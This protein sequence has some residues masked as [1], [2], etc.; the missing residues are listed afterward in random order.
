MKKIFFILV[1]FSQLLHAQHRYKITGK[2]VEESTKQPLEYATISFQ[3]TKNL[4]ELTG[5]ITDVKGHFSVEVPQGNYLLKIQFFSYKTHQIS[6]FSVQE[7]KN[8]GTIFLKD[9][10]SQLSGIE[11]VGKKSTVEMHLDKK[12]YNVGDDMTIKGGSVTDVLDNVPSVS[13][14]NEGNISLRGNENVKVLINGKPSALSGMNAESLKQLPAEMIEKVEI[15]TNPSARYEAEGS[16]GIINIILKKGQNIGLTG[17]VNTN[18]GVADTESYGASVNLNFRKNKFNIFNTTSYRYGSAIS[19]QIFEQEFL[20]AS[21]K[22]NFQN[23]FR[24][25]TRGQK[26]VT[27]NTGFEYFLTPK[28]TITNS[29]V[30]GSNR[31]WVNSQ[32]HITNL[33]ALK[34]LISDRL[35]LGNEKEKEYNLQYTFNIEQKFNDNGH[36]LTADYQYSQRNHDKNN[37][38]TDFQNEQVFDTQSQKDHLIKIDYIFPFS[39]KSQFE[40]GYQG[41]FKNRENQYD[42]FDFLPSPTL[43]TNFS[44]HL[45]YSENINAIYGQFGT[46]IGNFN[47]M[48]G[49]RF[50]DSNIKI[51]EIKSE[52]KHKKYASLFPSLFLGYEFS[53]TNQLSISYTR[54]LQRP[55]GRFINPFT[56]RTGN[57]NLFQGNPDLDPSYTNA[58]D[59]G[60]LTRLGKITLNTSAYYNY[61]TQIFQFVTT[62]SGQ[63]VTIN[64]L[65]V[66][67]MINTPIN[68]ATQN[69]YGVELTANFSPKTNWNFSWNINFYSDNTQGIYTYTNYLGEAI[70]QNLGIASTGWFSRISAKIPLPLG[71]D[72]QT[73]AVYTGQRKTA[74]AIIRPDFFV[75]LTLSKEIFNKKGT[76]SVNATDLLN[77]RRNISLV[78]TPNVHTYSEMQFRP[79]QILLNFS[80]RFGGQTDKKRTTKNNTRSSQREET[81]MEEMMF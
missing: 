45:F 81:S 32:V 70:S 55:M 9:E 76:L 36:K 48:L 80:Y 30:Y 60:Y 33:N 42:V 20:A 51:Q 28:T 40:A 12:I 21:Q 74:Q 4:K 46:K 71:I 44:N 77:S 68:L 49:L 35:R 56:S 72:F 5:G 63:F 11:V 41:S 16:A 52:Q 69:R 24:E 54:R 13:V 2:V 61:S 53:Q 29:F 15:I 64:G 66:P 7:N 18:V 39:K 3:N 22:N 57:T 79:R 23:E 38:I 58:F 78:E 8:L 59:L 1:L 50:E 34:T 6:N 10:V 26:G 17:S 65:L 27:L 75:N 37:F 31:K 14:D 43:N 62:E 47:A 67:V 25:N 73:N 19:E